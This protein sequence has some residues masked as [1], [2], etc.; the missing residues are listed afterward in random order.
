MDEW[1]DLIDDIP[2]L[3]KEL[4]NVSY[5][6]NI[7]KRDNG[8]VT[9]DANGKSIRVKKQATKEIAYIYFVLNKKL[10]TGYG[11]EAKRNAVIRERVG[12][13]SDWK[14]DDEILNA[15]NLLREDN[16]IIQ[17]RLIDTLKSTLETNLELFQS[18][19]ENSKK[20]V[21]FLQREV[22]ELTVEEITQR[23]VLIDSAKADFKLV[24]G[25]IND[26]A[27]SFEKL[28]S[29][30]TKLKQAERQQGKEVSELETN[31]AIYE[32]KTRRIL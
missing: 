5:L 27:S 7:Y 30:E 26:L 14:P 31:G 4:R 8:Q 21:E 9:S 16:K 24:L 18:V 11:N 17:Q 2:V 12:L 1:F 15:I 10:F 32:R 28:D 20:V 25:F 23:K 3:R 19:D 22:D 6:A 29:L 13:E